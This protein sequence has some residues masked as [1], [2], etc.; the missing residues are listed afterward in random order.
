MV[1]MALARMN[2]MYSILKAEWE[3]ESITFQE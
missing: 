2:Y 1:N 3:I